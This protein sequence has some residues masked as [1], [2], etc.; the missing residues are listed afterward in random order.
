MTPKVS[1]VPVHRGSGYF[2]EAL[3][4]ASTPMR[5]DGL[6][7]FG[8][9]DLY[10]SEKVETQVQRLATLVRAPVRHEERGMR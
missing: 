7:G 4:S 8:R 6:S 3:E 2:V 5:G 1:P 10:L 9:D